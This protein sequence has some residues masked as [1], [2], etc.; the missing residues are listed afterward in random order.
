[1]DEEVK[2]L[3][4]TDNNNN[5]KV[6]AAQAARHHH[7]PNS[8]GQLSVHDRLADVEA[9]DYFRQDGPP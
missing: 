8:R 7:L 4:H 9:R 1:V 3:Q 2:E 6:T 5:N